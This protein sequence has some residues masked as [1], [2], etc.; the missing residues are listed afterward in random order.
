MRSWTIT[1]REVESDGYRMFSGDVENHGGA[2][3]PDIPKL[4]DN[5]KWM[6]VE[7]ERNSRESRTD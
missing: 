2:A 6:L 3:S 4:M 1:I 5:L 7:Y